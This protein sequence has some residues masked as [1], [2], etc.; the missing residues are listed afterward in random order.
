MNGT[1]FN[2]TLSEGRWKTLPSAR[3]VRGL[4]THFAFRR[5]EIVWDDTEPFASDPNALVQCSVILPVV[6]GELLRDSLI[7]TM[8]NRF[9]PEYDSMVE[10]EVLDE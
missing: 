5:R 7:E 10:V 1:R 9:Q 2:I 4:L 6:N 8:L 3:A